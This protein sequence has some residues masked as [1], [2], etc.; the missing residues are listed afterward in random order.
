MFNFGRTVRRGSAGLLIAILGSNTVFASTGNVVGS[1]AGQFS[2]QSGAATYT[3]PLTIPPGLGEMKPE[4]SL[5]YSSSS[6]DG[7]L[8][9]GWSV[10]G[11]SAISLCPKTIAQDGVYI[12]AHKNNAAGD[13]AFCMDGQRLKLVSGTPGA[14]GAQYRSEVES[15]S[16]IKAMGWTGRPVPAWFRVETKAGQTIEFG[17]NPDARSHDAVN[18]SDPAIAWFVNKITDASDNYITFEYDRPYAEAGLSPETQ[19]KTISYTGNLHSGV[20]AHAQVVFHY[21]DREEPRVYNAAGHRFERKRIVD[22][23]ETKVHDNRVRAYKMTYAPH[24]R[25]GG[26]VLTKLQECAG[27]SANE[28]CLPETTF[29]WNQNQVQIYNEIHTLDNASWGGVEWIRT[30]DFNGDGLTD[31]ASPAAGSVHLKLGAPLG[32]FTTESWSTQSNWPSADKL[33]TGDF[34][35][36]GRTDFAFRAGNGI[37]LKLSRNGS[38]ADFYSHPTTADGMQFVSWGPQHALFVAEMNGDGRADLV[39]FQANASN[40]PPQVLLSYGNGFTVEAWGGASGY[41]TSTEFSTTARE[42]FPVD[43]N[44]DGITDFVSAGGTNKFKVYLADTHTKTFSTH[45]YATSMYAWS[46]QQHVVADFDG[47]GLPEYGFVKNLGSDSHLLVYPLLNGIQPSGTS[48]PMYGAN[49]AAKTDWTWFFDYNGDGRTDIV[50]SNGS[51][52]QV[53]PFLS[54]AFA[55]PIVLEGS[56]FLWGTDYNTYLGDF[57]GDGQ[58]DIAS[59]P[60][61]NRVSV[62]YSALHAVAGTEAYPS[63]AHVISNQETGRNA[64]QPDAIR[65]IESGDGAIIEISY[66]TMAQAMNGHTAIDPAGPVPEGESIVGAPIWLVHEVHS[67][68]GAGPATELRGTQYQYFN[69]H[70]ST[71]GRG[72]LAFEAEAARD[73][74]TG[75]YEV[76]E[77]ETTW[78]NNGS[79]RRKTSYLADGTRTSLLEQ[80]AATK[81]LYGGATKFPYVGPARVL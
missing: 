49:L 15:F 6:G 56:G 67:S 4:L 31:I 76:T 58:I 26:S 52:L 66:R 5:M 51:G 38:F 79:I 34:D 2:T 29:E 10:A 35:G 18:G 57:N 60:D 73:L 9:K 72:V 25:A 3:I 68:H 59:R 71:I 39:S 77:Y 61:G 11:L 55:A 75:N 12:P 42:S 54:D 50:T 47:D 74:L 13:L 22:F 65:R 27:D 30:G 32:G 41:P 64:A 78:P 7:I 37:R 62:M 36:D 45:P 46:S 43:V 20:N 8:G 23:I 24:L 17:L 63:G 1:T 80:T 44:A 28:Q 70:M 81:D 21:R 48:Y 69:L 19:I 40:Q 53:Y 14:N 33:M 16:R